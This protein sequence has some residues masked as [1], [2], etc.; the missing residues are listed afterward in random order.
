MIGRSVTFSES[1]SSTGRKAISVI[2]EFDQVDAQPL[3]GRGEAHRVFLDALRGAFDVAK[4]AP[5]GH[6]VVVHRGAPAE[7][8]VADEEAGERRRG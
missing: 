8:V 2:T 1:L 3:H 4:L 6:V 5:V 7:D